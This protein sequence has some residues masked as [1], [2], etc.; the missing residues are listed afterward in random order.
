M[1]EGER[2]APGD[3]LGK[4][5]HQWYNKFCAGVFHRR[6]PLL[7]R[8]LT[9]FLTDYLQQ[10]RLLRITP[11]HH[12]LSWAARL[13][14][15]GVPRRMACAG[16]QGFAASKASAPSVLLWF[17]KGAGDRSAGVLWAPSPLINALAS[18]RPGCVWTKSRTRLRR[19]SKLSFIAQKSKL[20]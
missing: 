5:R 12:N 10:A 9:H 15:A 18:T 6:L 8:H 2:A 19:S 3:G 17:M 16:V 7:T 14:G 20:L 13:F 1:Q 4:V 11:S